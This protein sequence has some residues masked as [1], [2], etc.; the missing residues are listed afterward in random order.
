MSKTLPLPPSKTRK[1]RAF[2][3]TRRTAA[4]FRALVEIDEGT[5]ASAKI[6]TKVYI[7]QQTAAGGFDVD[8]VVEGSAYAPRITG[9][10]STDTCDC[11]GFE[12]FGHCKH[13][14]VLR[15]LRFLEII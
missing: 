8:P 1:Y 3:F 13:L 9:S 10:T 12:R 2:R 4:G 15:A 14:D 7:F 5:S 6:L 11:E